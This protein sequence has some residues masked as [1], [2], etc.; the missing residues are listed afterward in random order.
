M[1]TVPYNTYKIVSYSVAICAINST[2]LEVPNRHV[3]HLG[4]EM[5]L[6]THFVLMWSEK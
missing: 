1:S 6:L 3:N 5:L 4:V 2:V